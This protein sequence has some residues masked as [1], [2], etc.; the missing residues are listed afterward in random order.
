MKF[1]RFHSW[2]NA[3]LYFGI[4]CIQ[5]LQIYVILGYKENDH[6]LSE[7]SFLGASMHLQQTCTAR[8]LV[9]RPPLSWHFAVL[10]IFL[11]TRFT[12]KYEETI[13]FQNPDFF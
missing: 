4:S 11:N 7:M 6:F 9:L 13:D 5:R 8:S 12:E 10:E 2:V 1:F 3:Q